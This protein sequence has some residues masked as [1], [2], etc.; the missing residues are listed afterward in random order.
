VRDVRLS[1]LKL[2]NRRASPLGD[3]LA[4]MRG[5]LANPKQVSSVMPSSRFLEQRLVRAADLARVRTAV[6]LGPG[7]GGTT[8]ALLRGLPSDARLLAIELS[9]EF[10]T[11]LLERI[12]DPRLLLPVG[13]AEQLAELLQA[14]RLPPPQVVVSGIPFSTLPEVA[15]RRIAATVGACLAPG[16]RF[17][18]YQVRGNVADYMAPHLGAP[19]VEWEWINMP[20]LRMFRWTKPAR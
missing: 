12:V 3:R 19:S 6:E 18:A 14:S 13:S 5:F 17:V 7:T 8:R 4:F 20:P 1:E 9:P 15:A 10:R 11:R 2:P 16:G